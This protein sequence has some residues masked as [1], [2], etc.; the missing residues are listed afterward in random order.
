MSEKTFLASFWGSI[1]E[2][3]REREDFSPHDCR[4][5]W[6]MVAAAPRTATLI[7]LMKLGQ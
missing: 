6:A 4:H 1:A 3:G 2:K 5:T 7:A